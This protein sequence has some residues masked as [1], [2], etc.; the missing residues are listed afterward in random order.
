MPG[1][2]QAILNSLNPTMA[3]GRINTDIKT[4]FILAPH[5]SAI[6][7]HAGNDLWER[8]NKSLCSGEFSPSLPITLDV[9]KRSGL[10][11]P[12]SILG[13]FDRLLYQS[14]IDLIAPT[15]ET[16][17][18][19]SRTFSNVL[20]DPD[21]HFQMFET[22]NIGWNKLQQF[23]RASSSPSS[24]LE[25]AIRADV[26]CYF[27]RIY[28][29]NLINLLHSAGCPSGAV[30]LL[31]TLLLSWMQKNSHGIIQGLFPSDLLGN[32]YLYW[33]DSDLTVRNI[34]SA[35]YVD[36]LYLF[37]PSLQEARVGLVN[38][39]K[40]LRVE[41][42]N[43]NESKSGIIKTQKL[44]HEETEIDQMF[45][46]ARAELE[47]Q[48]FPEWPYGFITS[49]LSDEEEEVIEELELEAIKSLYKRVSEVPEMVAEKIERFCLPL[50]AAEKSDLGVELSLARIFKNPHMAQVYCSYLDNLIGAHPEI[51]GRLEILIADEN[52]TF[53]WQLIWPLAVLIRASSVKG[54]TVDS[55]FRLLITTS[56][57][58]ALRAL[59][60]IFIGKHGNP[61]HRR[62]L[63]HHYSDEAS[64]FVRSAILFASRYFPASER[65]TCLGSWGSHST[66]N[67]LIAKAVKKIV[68]SS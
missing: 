47:D 62:N 39:C 63:K 27:E 32:F 49:W 45:S 33:L 66:V 58:V 51:G 2:D 59:C 50:L 25:W 38:L 9:P 20:K 30:N 1:L 52:L 61:G 10:T 24:G 53:D 60:A 34:P 65:K 35:R 54:A 43:L 56:R 16:L 13:P 42:L 17:I 64:D 15:V 31:E 57:A 18:D 14:L 5:Y 40:N 41:G 21:P 11:R 36:D 29:H 3:L 12:G 46:E 26:S 22:A 55:A 44:V 23:I 37:F 19:R 67:S 7:A 8:L 48:A 68:Q 28:Q 4:D 6:Y